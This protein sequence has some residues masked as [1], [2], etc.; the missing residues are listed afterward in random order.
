MKKIALVDVF[1]GEGYSDPTVKVVEGGSEYMFS[2]I[3]EMRISYGEDDFKQVADEDLKDYSDTVHIAMDGI[4]HSEDDNGAIHVI[5]IP[6]D[7]VVILLLQPCECEAKIF[8]TYDTM[9][10]AR[11][12]L[13]EEVYKESNGYDSDEIEEW[14]EEEITDS[15]SAHGKDSFDHYEIVS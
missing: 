15:F 2:S 9:E 12:S 11:K 5:E 3:E 1:N 7:K 6:K 14:E 13:K 8:G 10:D 4:G